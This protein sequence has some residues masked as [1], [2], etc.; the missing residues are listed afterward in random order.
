MNTLFKKLAEIEKRGLYHYSDYLF[1]RIAQSDTPEELNEIE[2]D[3]KSDLT[4]PDIKPMQLNR[5]QQ[6]IDSTKFHMLSV[7]NDAKT[8]KGLKSGY[9]TGILYLE[10][11]SSEI[12]DI[13]AFEE[14]KEKN[15]KS[16]NTTQLW[17]KFKQEAAPHST[18]TTCTHASPSCLSNLLTS[19][20]SCL[21]AYLS[22]GV[23]LKVMYFPLEWVTR[24]CVLREN[25]HPFF[26]KAVTTPSISLHVVYLAI[27]PPL[28]FS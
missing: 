10:P 1:S 24:P 22:L 8:P 27:A 18:K 13:N 17:Q 23:M 16:G 6:L 11:G 15:K 4:D 14:Y 9:I 19:R 21:Y 26:T 5:I 2:Q 12:Y 3:V 20:S 25:T 28:V 7:G